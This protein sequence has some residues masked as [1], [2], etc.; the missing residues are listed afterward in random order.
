MKLAFVFVS[1]LLAACGGT[2][3]EAEA[4]SAP[5][6][7][8]PEAADAGTTA[9]EPPPRS[10]S[11]APEAKVDAPVRASVR[12]EVSTDGGVVMIKSV[13]DAGVKV[14]GST[15]RIDGGFTFQGGFSFG[16]ADAGP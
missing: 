3:N 2:Q 10:V 11:P 6:V 15:Q 16:T 13:P 4:P 8:V 1:M 14:W 7:D 9:A 5:A 12:V